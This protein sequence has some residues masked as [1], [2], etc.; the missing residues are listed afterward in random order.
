MR[1]GDNERCL[2]YVGC[3]DVTLF[4]EVTGLTDDVVLPVLQAVDKCR[5]PIYP[6]RDAHPVANSYG[7][8][9]PDA[10]QTEVSLDLTIKKLAVVCSDNVPA[11]C[12]LND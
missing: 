1:D 9:A 10:F 5:L 7:I 4:A 11:S 2:I 8:R 3:N 12:V 6:W